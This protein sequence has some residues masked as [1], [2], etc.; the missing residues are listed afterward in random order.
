[1]S[2]VYDEPQH[3]GI[4]PAG[5]VYEDYWG[6]DETHRYTLPDGKQWFEF[7]IMDEGSRARFQKKTNQD[8][9]VNRDNTAKVKIDPVGERHTLIKDSVINWNLMQK[10]P[11]G[12]WSAAPFSPRGLEQW[13]E[14]AP[15][16][17]VDELEL[18]IRKANPSMQADMTV[19]M[20]DKEIER[21]YDMRKEAEKRE[22]GEGLS[23][24]K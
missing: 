10:G 13:L 18:A 2:E 23:G 11:D 21:L 1:M 3:P 9:T 22:S 8:M 14:H 4:E 12:D 17:I 24:S 6:T 19:E 20:I 7:K 16:K 15:P 5:E